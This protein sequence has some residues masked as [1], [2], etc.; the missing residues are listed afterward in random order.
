MNVKTKKMLKIVLPIVALLLIAA[1][2]VAVLLMTFDDEPFVVSLGT[3][4]VT[5]PM[6]NYYL[7][8]YK[9]QFLI[10]YKE[11]GLHDMGNSWRSLSS[12]GT[13]TWEERFYDEFAEILARKVAAAALFDAS[14]S[15]SR[16]SRQE[17]NERM[18]A[19]I[20][21]NGK[22]K[23][24]TNEILEKFDCDLDDVRR[25]VTLDYKVA[26]LYSILYGTDGSGLPDGLLEECYQRDYARV[27]TVFVRTKG[28]LQSDGTNAP[29]TEE[30]LEDADRKIATLR[31]YLEDGMDEKEFLLLQEQFNEDEI[32][33]NY[34]N[35][36]YLSAASVYDQAVIESSL[37]LKV[38]GA[39]L[40]EGEYGA[41]LVY[42]LSSP[43][44]AYLQESNAMW[45][46]GFIDSVTEREFDRLIDE[47]VG[48]VHF[49][50]EL[51]IDDTVILMPRNYEVLY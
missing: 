20:E 45:F 31:D 3:A 39:A 18:D 41:Y 19:I 12:D 25:A 27:M 44:G 13:R 48:D 24:K 22:T 2:A 21:S 14:Y 46:R 16:N 11:E 50:D 35:G 32:A 10:E 43:A 36:I 29:M 47:V 34:P 4:G 33:E 38:G 28:K 30:A 51:F 37:E 26:M 8:S 9:Y 40:V 1:I 49:E 17:I 6:F 15:L 23:A 5:E 42:R 7:A